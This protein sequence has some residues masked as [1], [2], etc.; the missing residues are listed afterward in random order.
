MIEEIVRGVFEVAGPDV[1]GGGDA[2]AYLVVSGGAAAMIDAGCD[3]DAKML[4]G[5]IKSALGGATLEWLILT[6]NHI[7]HI[8]GAAAIKNAFGCRIAMHAA[9]ADTL[10]TGDAHASAADWY[11]TT[12]MPANV[13]ARI[14]EPEHKITIGEDT[15]LCLHTPGHTPGSISVLLERDGERILFGQDIH[16]P[17]APQF[18]SDIMQWR[19]SM[20]KLLDLN[21]DILC[22]GHFGVIRPALMVESF[23]QRHLK[24][25]C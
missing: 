11:D 16:G 3:A 15:L 12:L 14:S 25:H 21:C 20:R 19:R 4:I 17:F 23:I 22:E 9:D 10:E 8:G 7:D 5:N 13:D 2:S 6:H 24:A 18:K 1:T